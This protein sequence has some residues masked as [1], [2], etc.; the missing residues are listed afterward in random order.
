MNTLNLFQ[1]LMIA[2]AA[3]LAGVSKTGITGL[4]ILSVAIAA[5]VLPSRD[6]VGVV[7]IM[8]LAGD[9][10]AI[11][12]YHRTASW[13]YLRRI[14]PWAGLGVL[15]GVVALGRVNNDSARRLIGAI[16]LVLIA[17]YF[18]RQRTVNGDDAEVLPFVRHPWLVGF[19]GVLAGFTTMV[20]NASGPIMI[21]YLLALRL[22][23]EVF[24][25]TTAW[26]F[27]TL[28]LFK[29][30]FSIGL[31]LINPTSLAVALPVVP[32]VVAGAL[33]GRFLLRVLDQRR[34]EQIALLLS[35]VAGIRLLW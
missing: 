6:S 7:L 30:P 17:A 28:N 10:M 14:F 19:T 9:A 23:K 20:A 25:G 27:L 4:N 31:G 22:P 8:F 35:L 1:W 3:F 5:S 12:I 29:T 11:A 16:L 2:L 21:L 15:V 26:F 34:F 13:P 18:I 24:V 33:L 32:F